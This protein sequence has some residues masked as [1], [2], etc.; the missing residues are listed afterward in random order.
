MEYLYDYGASQANGSLGARSVV[1]SQISE[2][3]LAPG[4]V[5]FYVV[6]IFFTT[7]V[8]CSMVQYN[9]LLML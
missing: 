6:D 1:L 5:N 3:S 4:S 8:D 7:D 2:K 9:F